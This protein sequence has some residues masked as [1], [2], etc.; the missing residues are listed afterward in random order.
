MT[1]R[2]SQR[3]F[4]LIELLTTLALGAIISTTIFGTFIAQQQLYLRQIGNAE[5]QQNARVANDVVERVVRQ[6]G[7]G[8]A[9]GSNAGVVAIGSC[10]A[11]DPYACNGVDGG[12]D[13][14]RIG[15]AS[16]VGF[17]Y[18]ATWDPDPIA[19]VLRIAPTQDGGG[20]ALVDLPNH[21]FAS[22]TTVM[23]SGACTADDPGVVATSVLTIDSE[24]GDTD[25]YHLYQY[26]GVPSCSVGYVEGFNFGRWMT[27]DF[28]IDRTVPEHPTLMMDPDGGG[29]DAAF[30]VA[31]D[32]DDLQVRYGVDTDA[33]PDDAVDLWCDDL[34]T[35]FCVTGFATDLENARRVRA[36]DVA[37][38]SRTRYARSPGEGDITAHDHTITAD[39]Y[40]RWV[41]RAV[42]ALKNLR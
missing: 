25:W 15:N 16:D 1:L 34:R 6:A 24:S 30:V 35:A 19:G 20:N 36:V 41:Y 27:T 22:G 3:G 40:R 38:V 29:A 32:I 11:V 26:S 4:T 37:V 31:Y 12:S 10:D 18:D 13:R 7:W 9:S 42:V 23:V 33:T 8:L 28:F 5:A 21:P 14:L 17:V 39:G 2:Y